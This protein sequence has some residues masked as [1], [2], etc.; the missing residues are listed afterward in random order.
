MERPQDVETTIAKLKSFHDGDLGVV[1]AVACGRSAI[2]P[3]RALLFERERSGLYQARCRAVAA[4]A[5]LG[6]HEV[7]IEFLQAER[8]IADPVERVGEDAVINAAALALSKVQ[9]PRVLALLLRL[10][11]RPALNGVIGALGAFVSV[12]AIPVLIDALE[13]DASRPT[14][15]AALK[16]LGK[17]ARAAL[18]RTVDARLPSAERESES[19]AR[20]RRSALGILAESPTHGLWRA[21]RHL[22]YDQ[23]ARV[24]A[25][26]SEIALAQAPA[27]E[28]T[29]ATRHLIK[30]LTHDDRMLRHDIEDCL[31]AHFSDVRE[32]VARFLDETLP[33]GEDAATRKRTED[34]LR[35]VVERAKSA[36]PAP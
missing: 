22:A 10:A 29:D 35:R 1:E 14:A 19:S 12:E 2:A 20:R 3:L 16:K 18:L 32:A 36:A 8:V 21:I 33:P 11:Q 28:R 6:A 15:A 5:A 9:E 27:S 26:A 13:E 34:A 23:D 4:L 31:V 24:A 30:L 17:P 7:L 25:L